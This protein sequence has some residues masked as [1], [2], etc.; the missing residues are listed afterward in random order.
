MLSVNWSFAQRP[1]SQDGK[2]ASL[3]LATTSSNLVPASSFA[4]DAFEPHRP[5]ETAALPPHQTP[6]E[7]PL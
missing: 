2:A 1:G 7:N 5:I 6:L 3:H 4:V